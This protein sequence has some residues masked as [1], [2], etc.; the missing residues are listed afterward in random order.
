M[1]DSLKVFLGVLGGAVLALLLVAVFSGGGMDD[2]GSMVGGGMMGGG[3]FGALF[4]L[5][6]WVLVIALVVALITWIVGQS[7]QR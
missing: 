4:M 3:M 7:R 1:N 5:L 2:M 6:F